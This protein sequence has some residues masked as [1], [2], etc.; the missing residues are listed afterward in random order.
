MSRVTSA[1]VI[2]SLEKN[3]TVCSQ[4]SWWPL[5]IATW[6]LYNRCHPHIGRTWTATVLVLGLAVGLLVPIYIFGAE[7]VREAGAALEW[8]QSLK[9]NNSAPPDWFLKIP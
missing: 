4:S 3:R 2:D 7:A 6:P 8:L 5:A 9:S 1:C